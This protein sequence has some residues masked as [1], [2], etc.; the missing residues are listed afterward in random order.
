[1]ASRRAESRS[2]AASGS[3]G[4]IAEGRLATWRDCR[5]RLTVGFSLFAGASAGPA[6]GSQHESQEVPDDHHDPLDRA[7]SVAPAFTNTERL[8]LSGFL[9][10][11]SGLTRQAY[12]LDL[13]QYASWCQQHQLHL[14]H[15]PPRCGGRGWTMGPTPQ[16]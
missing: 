12:E 6:S 8:A 13:Q 11:Y 14:F 15:P 5:D 16:G 9:A 1:M 3:A 4:P 10:G 7:G 2:G